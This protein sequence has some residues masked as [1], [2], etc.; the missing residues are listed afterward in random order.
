MS[1][2][3]INSPIFRHSDLKLIGKQIVIKKTPFYY[4][5]K[6]KKLP[7]FL[8]EFRTKKYSKIDHDQKLFFQGSKNIYY[9]RSQIIS[10]IILRKFKEKKIKIL[11]YGCNNGSLLKELNKLNFINLFGYDINSNYK[12]FF[13]KS[14]IRYLNKIKSY[15]NE[16][17]LIIFSHSIAYT[18]NI[19]KLIKL[20]KKILK[21]KGHILINLQNISKRPLNFLYGDQKYHFNKKM[22]KN[23]FGKIGKLQFIKERSLNHELIFIIR[24]GKNKNRS[25]KI[26]Y[27][28]ISKIKRMITNIKKINS[29]CFVYGEN[30]LG[31]LCNKLINKKIIAIVS[32]KSKNKKFFGK[33]IV[34]LKNF[35]LKKSPLI[36]LNDRNNL[37]AKKTYISKLIK[38]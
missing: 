21:K 29:N 7:S 15:Q 33:R 31:A 4:V 23:Y 36:C 8:K 32:T 35:Q 6:L 10:K 16:F 22:V 20:I 12:K 18:Q 25:K 30:I 24:L 11:D 5:N 34:D 26:S 37:L 3:I 13:N 2:Q 27:K 17:D 1:L 14:K 19:K 28:E 38:V 9:K